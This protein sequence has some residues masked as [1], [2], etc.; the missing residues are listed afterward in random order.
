MLNWHK[1]GLTTA[2]LTL[3]LVQIPLYTGVVQS[4]L[5]FTLVQSHWI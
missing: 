1:M 3:V 4:T 2:Q 5:V